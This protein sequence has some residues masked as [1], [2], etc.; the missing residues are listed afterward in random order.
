MSGSGCGEPTAASML[1]PEVAGTL[2]TRTR[3][4]PWVLI[5]C[6]ALV[7]CQAESAPK[8][9]ASQ[10]STPSVPS[11]WREML[12]APISG[13]TDYGAAWTGSDL[14]V[15]GGLEQ[16]N[17]GD[18][19]PS[20]TGAL[21]SPSRNNWRVVEDGPLKAR[22]G[23]TLLPFGSG[24]AVW[25]GIDPVDGSYI[26]DGAVYDPGADTWNPMPAFPLQDVR[27][28]D[29]IGS[30][31]DLFVVVEAN[32]PALFHLVSGADAWVRE[33]DPPAFPPVDLSRATWTGS[34]F[35]WLLYPTAGLNAV[36]I[37]YD[38]AARTWPSQSTVAPLPASLGQPLVW[39]GH[40]ALVMGSATGRP[41]L[42]A[43]AALDLTSTTWR[44]L[45]AGHGCATETASWTGSVLLQPY[46]AR[47]FTEVDGCRELPMAPG[48]TREGIQPVWT[49]AEL[50]VWSG[51]E[52]SLGVPPRS[53]GLIYRP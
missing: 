31:T 7:A 15:W 49:G 3:V 5:A 11:G 53:D 25:G 32:T 36:A 27:A 51:S 48:P 29:V 41:P 30:S 12:A 44:P 16:S 33:D 47:Q 1:D 4:W 6:L 18:S 13:R 22:S 10:P 21:F 43:A 24:V 39:T 14:F 50:L 17:D 20:A 46:P 45:P 28:A 9:S 8:P 40:D 37:S 2:V 19:H 35:V 52:G 42:L 34:G 38:G 23:P 26:A